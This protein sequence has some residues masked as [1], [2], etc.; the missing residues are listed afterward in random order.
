MVGMSV[1]RSA[2]ALAAR[3]NPLKTGIPVG[4]LLS[5]SALRTEKGEYHKYTKLQSK[6]L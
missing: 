6:R 3:L 2:A 1:L 5:G 4:T